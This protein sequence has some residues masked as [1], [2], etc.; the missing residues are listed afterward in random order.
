MDRFD[1]IFEMHKVFSTSRYPVPMKRLMEQ[2]ECS[3][4]TVNRILDDMR[5]FLGAPIEYDRELN[6]YRYSPGGEHEYELPGM[7][8]NASELYALLAA[9]HLLEE[10]QPGLLS[11]H[12][13]PLRKRIE[14]LLGR[15]SQGEGDLSSR[16]RITRLGSRNIPEQAFGI[17]AQALMQRLR[18]HIAY[19][20]RGRGE[21]TERDISP[22]RMVHYRNN[23]YVDAWCHLREDLRSFALDRVVESRVLEDEAAKDLDET[24]LDEHFASGYGIFSGVANRHA[25]LL[26]SPQRARWVADEHWHPEQQG[27]FLEDGRY[28]LTLPY[29]DDREL[30]MDVLRHGAEVEVESPDSLR[31]A[32]KGQLQRALARY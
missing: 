17:L 18:V 21:A 28:R 19:D 2:L 23:W 22:Q 29:R 6:G 7:W 12:I 13:E 16:I 24:T 9:D 11:Q 27:E 4:A 26:F 1:R 30:I 5:T 10:V 14:E 3:R 31:E 32:V 15:S 20:G 25:I 8:F